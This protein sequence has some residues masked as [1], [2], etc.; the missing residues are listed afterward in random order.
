MNVSCMV[1]TTSFS[2]NHCEKKLRGVL[3]NCLESKIVGM[4]VLDC[5]R[6]DRGPELVGS[7]KPNNR[8]H[9]T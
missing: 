9:I 7:Q 2:V 5:N 3:I 4:P 8:S 1:A 6:V